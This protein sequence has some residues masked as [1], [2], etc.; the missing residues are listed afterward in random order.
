M[1]MWD[2]DALVRSS[3]A[4]YQTMR[5]HCEKQVLGMIVVSMS[6]SETETGIQGILYF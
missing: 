3:V 6:Q 4:E 1:F 5:A 2:A